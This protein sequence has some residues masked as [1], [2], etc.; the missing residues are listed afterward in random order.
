M[1]N[2]KGYCVHCKQEIFDA[3]NNYEVRGNFC[4]K[5]DTKCVRIGKEMEQVVARVQEDDYKNKEDRERDLKEYELIK[6]LFVAI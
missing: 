1:H 5:C 2:V 3:E 6:Q 4:A